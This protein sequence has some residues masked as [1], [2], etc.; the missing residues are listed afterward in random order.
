MKSQTWRD[1]CA[2]LA[3][4]SKVSFAKNRVGSTKPETV[5]EWSEEMGQQKGGMALVEF[6][7]HFQ[8]QSSPGSWYSFV[9]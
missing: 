1:A 9:L 2:L 3:C 8:E 6:G 5:R 4:A 7:L